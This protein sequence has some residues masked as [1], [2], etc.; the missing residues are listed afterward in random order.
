M[1]RIVTCILLSSI[2]ISGCV[3]QEA[4]DGKT[5]HN[6][7]IGISIIPPPEWTKVDETSTFLVKGVVWKNGKSYLLISRYG[8]P[9]L[10]YQFALFGSSKNFIRDYKK[11]MQQGFPYAKISKE[12]KTT[13]LGYPAYTILWFDDSYMN[14]TNYTC[15]ATKG[16]YYF[17]VICLEKEKMKDFKIIADSIDT[18]KCKM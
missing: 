7:S 4:I 10:I 9:K 15:F 16:Y 14:M 18:L 8:I 5:Y 17:V 2:I 1:K 6:N 11:R 3:N 12:G 13:F